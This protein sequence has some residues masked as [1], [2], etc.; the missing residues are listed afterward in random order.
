MNIPSLSGRIISF[1]ATSK[2]AFSKPENKS[3]SSHATRNP[4]SPGSGREPLEIPGVSLIDLQAAQTH[5][6]LQQEISQTYCSLLWQ[7]LQRQL[8]TLFIQQAQL[9]TAPNAQQERQ[10]DP[11]PNPAPPGSN[12]ADIAVLLQQ[13]QLQQ[14][15][16]AATFYDAAI[17]NQLG[18]SDESTIVEELNNLHQQQLN[19][20]TYQIVALVTAN[21][22]QPILQADRSESS[23]LQR[24]LVKHL[25]AL[26]L[27]QLQQQQQNIEF[28]RQDRLTALA[29]IRS[30][31][32]NS[33]ADN[34]D[35]GNS[36][37]IDLSLQ[38]PISSP[39]LQHL[40]SKAAMLSLSRAHLLLTESA[41]MT[42]LIGAQPA[43]TGPSRDAAVAAAPLQQYETNMGV[44]QRLDEGHLAVDGERS[45][46][47]ARMASS[48]P[49]PPRATA[50]R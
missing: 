43:L 30:L 3:L 19:N 24:V 10:P 41:A 16:M 14:Q 21:G 18:L 6:L 2:S 35:S 42:P 1:E 4:D 12:F 8:S 9:V 38:Q 48:P 27:L 34:R 31:R 28:L 13:Q 5:Y 40:L 29:L 47:A 17:T 11:P 44:Y 33:S 46:A 25:I 20:L 39:Q 23:P 22:E 26:V 36:S 50:A 49:P 37:N 45:F 7:E 15:I 32:R